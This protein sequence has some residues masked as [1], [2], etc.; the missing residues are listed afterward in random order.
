MTVVRSMRID[1]AAQPRLTDRQIA[2][3]GEAKRRSLIA[4]RHRSWRGD[5]CA[6]CWM[7]QS[8]RRILWS[9]C[10]GQSPGL[11]PACRFAPPHP[12]LAQSPA[13][14]S[15]GSTLTGL[16]RLMICSVRCVTRVDICKQLSTSLAQGQTQW[17]APGCWTSNHRVAGVAQRVRYAGVGGVQHV[18]QSWKK[19]FNPLL[20]ETW[21]ATQGD[22]RC[23]IFM[24]QI[25][26]HPPISA[27]EML[28]PGV[29]LTHTDADASIR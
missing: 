12:Q 29:H 20:G 28:G 10:D 9:A 14:A 27:F 3:D 1:D 8:R 23:S 22:G 2:G 17:A 24:E 25:S 6:G 16:A 11:W 15:R 21:Q 4:A 19:P 7:K 26:H 13:P 5:A 18:F